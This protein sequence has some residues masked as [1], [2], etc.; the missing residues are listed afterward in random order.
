M[1]EKLSNIFFKEINRLTETEADSMSSLQGKNIEWAKKYIPKT[2]F[3]IGEIDEQQKE[4][5]L[6]LSKIDHQSSGFMKKILPVEEL[7]MNLKF[8]Y[9]AWGTLKDLMAKLVSNVLDLG[10][11][12]VD[13]NFGILLRNDKVKNT[14]IPEICNKYSKLLD[15][16]GTDKARNEAAHRGNLLDDD[17]IN[18]K[19]KKAAIE[20]GRFSLLQQEHQRI[21]EEEY[22]RKNKLFY[23]ELKE[24]VENKRFEYQNHYELTMKLNREIAIELAT[25]WHQYMKDYKL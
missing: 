18:I 23:D 12:D 22:S 17:V 3:G 15:I 21:S 14:R 6:L 20:A 8:Y 24:L 1:A 4:I 13:L 19:R 9:I 2:L 11:A 25:I 5:E 16:A 7:L 10:I